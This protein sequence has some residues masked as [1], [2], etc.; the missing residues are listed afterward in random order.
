LRII[1][2]PEWLRGLVGRLTTRY[3]SSRAEPWHVTDAP[4]DFVDTQLRAIVGLEL[5]V[6]R[7][8]GK[9]KAS[10]NR[11]PADRDRVVAGLRDLD[12]ANAQ[13]MAKYVA[14]SGKS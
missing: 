3:E 12:D 6:T 5:S 7:L 11:P 14:E 2:D 4:A 1:D 13:A 10:Q 9:W 8:I